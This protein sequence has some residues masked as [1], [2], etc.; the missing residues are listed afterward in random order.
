MAKDDILRYQDNKKE[1]TEQI[2]IG[3]STNLIRDLKVISFWAGGSYTDYIRVQLMKVASKHVKDARRGLI[4]AYIMGRISEKDYR[5][6]FGEAPSKELKAKRAITGEKAGKEY[7]EK[8]VKP[9]LIKSGQ[10]MTPNR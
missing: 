5:K 10:D 7:F 9:S 3:L 1:L 8:V 4:A 2:K 6:A